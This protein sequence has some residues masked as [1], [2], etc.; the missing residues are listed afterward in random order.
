V[1]GLAKVIGEQGKWAASTALE[2]IDGRDPSDIPLTRNK[3]GQ[4]LVNLN[5]AEKLDIVFSPEILKNA[6]I[7]Q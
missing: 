6:E 4:I 3:E 7:Y 1:F 5:L 2:I